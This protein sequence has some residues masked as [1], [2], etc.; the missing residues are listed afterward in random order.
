MDLAPQRLELGVV[1]NAITKRVR[2]PLGADAVHRM[3]PFQDWAGARRARDST[4][5]RS[6]PSPAPW[7]PAPPRAASCS[8]G[9]SW[10]RRDCS[11]VEKAGRTRCS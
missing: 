3:V 6:G 9:R 4:P 1:Q 10:S 2:T 11:S 7:R 5:T 8:H